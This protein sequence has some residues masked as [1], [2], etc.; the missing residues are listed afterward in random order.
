MADNRG[1]SGRPLARKGNKLGTPPFVLHLSVTTSSANLVDNL[2]FKVRVVDMWAN[3]TGGSCG[4]VQTPSRQLQLALGIKTS[5]EPMRLM[6]FI[7]KCPRVENLQRQVHRAPVS[8]TF[9]AYEF[10][11]L[12]DG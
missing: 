3:A 1:I 11:R 6:M 2:D 9:C 5:V 10:R 7:T 4:I 8:F 12:E